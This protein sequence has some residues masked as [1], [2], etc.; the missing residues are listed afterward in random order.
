M[1]ATSATARP[2]G[3]FGSR[4]FDIVIP[5]KPKM[6][7]SKENEG[8]K[9]VD[10]EEMSDKHKN[11]LGMMEASS[12]ARPPGVNRNGKFVEVIPVMREKRNM[13][14]KEGVRKADF[15]KRSD[16]YENS[17]KM[18]E[19]SESARPPGGI[20]QSKEMRRWRSSRASKDGRRDI[21]A[22]DVC[23][24]RELG[25]WRASLGARI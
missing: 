18:M 15:E 11:S 10:F 14:E 16:L 25:S 2:P 17:P 7:N 20:A 9:K 1:V 3:E 19:A 4:N 21:R 8:V 6:W 12:T 23:G 13:K 24:V 22:M 5:I